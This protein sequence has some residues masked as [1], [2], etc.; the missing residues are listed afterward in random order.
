ML[1]AEAGEL[2]VILANHSAHRI[3]R[4]LHE[5][6]DLSIRKFLRVLQQECLCTLLPDLLT[7]FS[8]LVQAESE[9][10]LVDCH[11]DELECILRPHQVT[12][13][14][15]GLVQ[16]YQKQQHKES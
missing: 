10:E 2:R 15:Q 12:V 9:H 16:F 1:V 4:L 7:L 14:Q 6:K 5:V 13:V 3:D 8:L 11:G